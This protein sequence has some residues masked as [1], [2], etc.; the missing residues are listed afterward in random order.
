MSRLEESFS[1]TKL[2]NGDRA[3]FARVVDAYS[4]MIYRLGLKMLHNAQ[5]AE[6]VLQE[7]FIKAYKN[8]KD[9]KG[10]SKVST[11]LYS[12]ASNES[13]MLL[14]KKKGNQ[15]S[16]DKTLV[17]DNGEERKTTRLVDWCCLPEKELMS[18]EAMDYL[19]RAVSQLS[20]A[21]RAVFLLRDME[22]L[23]TRETAKVLA[24]SEG[25]AKTRLSRARLRL[26]ELLSGYYGQRLETI[27]GEE[28]R[29]SQ[30]GTNGK[31]A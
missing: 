26:R 27:P 23:S 8:F 10:N 20:E 2:R 22:G 19:D 14:R 29:L 7:T 13:L 17:K 30:N 1:L 24:I 31:V 3:E 12:I 11:W 5:D 4:D 9:F 28:A 21:N 16:L 25:A 6:D 15:F 18:S